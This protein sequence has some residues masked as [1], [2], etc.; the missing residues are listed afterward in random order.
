MDRGKVAMGVS[1]GWVDLNSSSV[2][3][4]GAINILHLLQGVAHVAVGISKV[5]VD[6]AWEEGGRG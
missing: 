6:P 5:G 3:L 1:K 4:H 2:A